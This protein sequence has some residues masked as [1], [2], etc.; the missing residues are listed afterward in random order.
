MGVARAAGE[1]LVVAPAEKKAPPRLEGWASLMARATAADAHAYRALASRL[2]TCELTAD[3]D[4][5]AL[6]R[7]ELVTISMGLEEMTEKYRRL[8][9]LG[10]CGPFNPGDKEK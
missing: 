5:V 9:E 4:A 1:C 7:A 2:R 6:V 8:A 10:E 3:W